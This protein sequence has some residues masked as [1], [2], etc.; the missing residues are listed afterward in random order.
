MKRTNFSDIKLG[1]VVHIRFDFEDIQGYKMRPAVVVRKDDDK[2]TVAKITSKEHGRSYDYVIKNIETM[3]L[4]KQSRIRCENQQIK[5]KNDYSYFSKIGE[6]APEELLKVIDKC[7][8]YNL[9]V[10]HNPIAEYCKDKSTG[11]TN[12]DKDRER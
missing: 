2:V 3:G 4:K 11:I 10:H 6:M 9:S 1:D 7:K 5:K 12:N 8:S